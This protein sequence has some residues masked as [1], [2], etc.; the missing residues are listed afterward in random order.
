MLATL[1]DRTST[2][3]TSILVV[4]VGGLGCAAARLLAGSRGLKL[5]LI[6]PDNVELSNLQRQVL[7]SDA[8]I[9][10]AKA[11]V[12]A[13]TLRAGSPHAE[14]HPI[15]ARLDANNAARLI[16]AHDFV[17]DATDDPAT[18]FLINAVACATGVP[19]CYGGVV[20]TGGQLMSV[21]PGRTACLACVFPEDDPGE[22][23]AAGG[24]TAQ[25]ILA[26]VAGVIGSLQAREA[27]A[28]LNCE[29]SK[30]VECT[31]GT[32]NVFRPGRMILYEMRG[33][34]W[35][36]VDFPKNPNCSVCARLQPA[37]APRRQQPCPL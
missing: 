7:Y 34:V 28:F 24:C 5:T 15:I 21:V 26:P 25:G 4:G 22:L 9:G 27:F 12:A 10:E 14:I 36:T 29:S 37:Q 31:A 18:K 20:R 30:K 23:A 3:R 13:A 2:E 33:P 8:D 1:A 16:A 11:D 35:R 6:D 32:D 17:I 19:F